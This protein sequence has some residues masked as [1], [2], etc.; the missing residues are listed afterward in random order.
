MFLRECEPNLFLRGKPA[1]RNYQT[2]RIEQLFHESFMRYTIIYLKI[3]ELLIKYFCSIFL[4]GF[5]SVGLML[6]HYLLNATSI[7]E[8]Y[9]AL[10]N[11]GYQCSV[12]FKICLLITF[13]VCVYENIIAYTALWIFDS[14]LIYLCPA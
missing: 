3:L 4:E 11:C 10:V 9:T 5:F 6:H 13:L 14:V 2:T 1:I 12:Y 8:I 7:V